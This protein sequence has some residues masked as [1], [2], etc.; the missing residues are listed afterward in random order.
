MSNFLF[1]GSGVFRSNENFDTSESMNGQD[2]IAP[3]ET[4]SLA[5][6]VSEINADS[7]QLDSAGVSFD[8][9]EAA[10][11]GLETIAEKVAD[12]NESGGIDEDYAELVEASVESM[13]KLG[14]IGVKYKSLG[15]PTKESFSNRSNRVQLGQVTCE[16]LKD[17]AKT[18]WKHIVEAIKKSIEWVRNYFNKI[19]GA[20]ERLERRAA[21]LLASVAKLGANEDKKDIEN[22]SLYNAIRVNGSPVT[23]AQL[24]TLAAEAKHLFDAQKKTADEFAKMNIGDGDANIFQPTAQSYGLKSAPS[25]VS[26][27]VTAESDVNVSCSSRFPGE[28]VIYLAIPKTATGGDSEAA[29][30]FANKIKAGA[31][32]LTEKKD[33]GKALKPLALNEVTSF[34][35]AIKSF[36]GTISA[37]KR[38]L[39]DINNDKTK[40]I[41]TLEK[42]LGKGDGR[43]A[44][45]KKG[46]SQ[47]KAKAN[48]TI[49]RKLM[50]EPAASFAAHSI[51]GMSS[52]LQY[53]ELSARQYS[54]A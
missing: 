23:S 18:V 27:R 14:R 50:D 1:P 5:G 21:A 28:T 3:D 11:D 16:A 45:D 47:K 22:D 51:R 36:A 25:E 15:I 49:F 32:A 54:A 48:A 53:A 39:T 26:K 52:A 31:V 29:N 6:A 40:F 20:A 10:A 30:T 37:Y 42:F 2:A 35:E 33:E 19:F 34:A 43:D 13:L 46:E 4:D 8:A 17:T 9:A 38:N 44:G 12:K 7:A 41:A 24:S